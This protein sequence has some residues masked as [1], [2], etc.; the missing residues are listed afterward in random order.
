MLLFENEINYKKTKH[1]HPL[2]SS[3]KL[4]LGRIH[5]NPHQ[6]QSLF[7]KTAIDSNP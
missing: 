4:A 3:V 7:G 1:S 5:Y 6:N 2:S